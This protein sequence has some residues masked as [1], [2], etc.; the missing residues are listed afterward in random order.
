MKIQTFLS[1]ALVTL[2]GLGSQSAFAIDDPPRVVDLAPNPR[3]IDGGPVPL[4]RPISGPGERVARKCAVAVTRVTH[5]AVT[6]NDRK[7]NRTVAAIKRLLGSDHPNAEKLA[8]AMARRCA[9][10]INHK[11][12]RAL[13][14][15]RRI[16]DRCIAHLLRLNRPDLARRLS[17]LCDDKAKEVEDSRQDA[18]AMLRTVL[19]DASLS[20]DT[21]GVR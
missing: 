11:S 6:F 20:V 4:P 3:V 1:C 9:R 19:S 2:I 16:C 17:D 5:K 18:L 14:A 21:A 7:I 13:R 15:I 10:L 8:H 12:D